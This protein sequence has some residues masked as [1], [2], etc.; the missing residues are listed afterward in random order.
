MREGG[1]A[2]AFGLW[3]C[4]NERGGIPILG[5]RLFSKS[6]KSC[7]YNSGL[8]CNDFIEPNVGNIPRFSQ[9]G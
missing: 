5:L 7:I 2:M 1:I 4:R 9:A 3:V 6:G 8:E